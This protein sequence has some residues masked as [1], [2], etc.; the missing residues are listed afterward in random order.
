MSEAPT[1]RH[2]R[3]R[4]LLPAYPSATEMDAMLD[5]A[6]NP[7]NW[8]LVY[9]VWVT[10][11]RISEALA[12]RVGDLTPNGVRLLNEKQG[13]HAEKHVYVPGPALARLREAVAGLPTTA[14]LFT[15]LS[16]ER[17]TPISRQQGYNVVTRIARLAGVFKLKH[18]IRRPAWPHS[19]RHAYAVHLINSAVPLNAVQDQL[20]HSDLESTAVYLRLADPDRERAIGG[21]KF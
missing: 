4:P 18:G 21:V 3:R 1:R 10:G 5:A 19:I 15:P 16:G 17:P 6:D 14:F 9:L 7:R 20:G 8:L 12:A 13:G 11:A 2:G